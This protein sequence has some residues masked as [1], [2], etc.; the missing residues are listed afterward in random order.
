MWSE[1]ERAQAL[2]RERS[3]LEAVVITLDELRDGLIDVRDLVEMA[4]EEED[5][6]T[7]DALISDLEAMRFRYLNWSSGACSRV[8]WTQ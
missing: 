4:F 6:E 7:V 1:P 3:A 8:R 2:G 5:E